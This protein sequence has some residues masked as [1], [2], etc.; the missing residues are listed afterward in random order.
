[1]YKYLLVLFLPFLNGAG[2]DESAP[3]PVPGQTKPAEKWSYTVLKSLPVTGEGYISPTDVII[4]HENYAW[5]R[6]DS[7]VRNGPPTGV[8]AERTSKGLGV[9]VVDERLDWQVVHRNDF[10]NALPCMTWRV[11]NKEGKVKPN[12]DDGPTPKSK[13]KK[14]PVTEE[15]V[16][17]DQVRFDGG[18]NGGA[19]ERIAAPKTKVLIGTLV[20]AVTWDNLRREVTVN[21]NPDG[22][23]NEGLALQLTYS[24]DVVRQVRTDERSVFD[25]GMNWL[26]ARARI[27]FTPGQGV[28]G[29]RLVEVTP[30]KAGSE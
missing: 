27:H 18:S 11:E 20:H 30:R 15:D 25:L 12:D 16:P 19:G 7:K 26:G 28:K 17:S 23:V 5:L 10:R 13:Q 9:V 8:K 22:K 14:G 4:D 2:P 6:A 1:M 21:F 3:E 24:Y 29:Y